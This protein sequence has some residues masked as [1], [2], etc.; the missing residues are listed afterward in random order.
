MMHGKKSGCYSPTHFGKMKELYNFPNAT[1]CWSINSLVAEGC[2]SFYDVL[3]K[4]CG[5]YK[6]HKEISMS[7]S[8]YFCHKLEEYN[9]G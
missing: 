9:L 7:R 6:Y 4:H 8:E 3:L 5:K 2:R 1:D